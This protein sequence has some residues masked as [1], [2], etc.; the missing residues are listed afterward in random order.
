[1]LVTVLGIVRRSVACS[2]VAGGPD[3][4]LKQLFAQWAGAAARTSEWP[5]VQKTL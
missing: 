4:A 2:P 1:M 3:T 5:I